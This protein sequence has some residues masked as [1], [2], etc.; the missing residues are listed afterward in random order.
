[1]KKIPASTK[2]SKRIGHD[3]MTISAKF[4]S[5]ATLSFSINRSGEKLALAFSNDQK[6]LQEQTKVMSKW[7]EPH[8]NE[9]HQQ[10]F[11]RLE[12]VLRASASGAE[13]ISKVSHEIRGKIAA[14]KFV[15]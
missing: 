4:P 13:V 7:L 15:F 8:K 1:M 10:R 9:T 14:D 12:S 11:D 3:S 2:V 6:V 5:G